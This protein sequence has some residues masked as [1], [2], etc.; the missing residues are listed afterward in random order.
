MMKRRQVCGAIGIP[1]IASLSGC[2]ETVSGIVERAASTGSDPDERESILRS[3]NDGVGEWNDATETRDR[4]IGLFNDDQYSVA[5]EEF[6]TAIDRYDA[7][8]AA[9]A[10]AERLASEIDHADAED[11]SSRAVANTEFQRAATVAGLDAATAAADGAD[12][13]TI[14]DFVEQYRDRIERAEETPLDPPEEVAAA[15][16][17]NSG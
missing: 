16:G 1:V 2:L 7:A 8:E 9:F 11:S 10:A 5:I 3:Y 12:A 6:E 14:N 15:L 17:F 13:A 4:G